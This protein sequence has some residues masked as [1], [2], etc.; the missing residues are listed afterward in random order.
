MLD[1]PQRSAVGLPPAPGADDPAFEDTFECC[2]PEAVGIRFHGTRRGV[3]QSHVDE[4]VRGHP[5][6]VAVVVD[7]GDV[8]AL[9]DTSRVGCLALTT[10]EVLEGNAAALGLL[11]KPV[12]LTNDEATIRHDRGSICVSIELTSPGSDR[13][14]D[15]ETLP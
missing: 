9:L 4:I 6:R 15:E 12:R 13:A 10:A 11:R 7:R 5:D 2:S 14:P 1:P 3:P 8:V